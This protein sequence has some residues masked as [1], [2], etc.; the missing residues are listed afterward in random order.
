MSHPRFRRR[1][2]LAAFLL[3]A[4]L[5]T[6][7]VVGC[8]SEP[9]VDK[10]V[11]IPARYTALPAKKVPDVF[12]DTVYEKCDLINTEPFLVNGY[13]FVSNLDGTGSCEAPNAVRDYMVKEMM[14]HKWDSRLSGIRTPSPEEAMRDPRNAIVQVDGYLPPGVR[15]GQ[16][17]DIQVSALADSA[18]TSLAQGDLFQ[19]EL[20]IRGADPIDPGG[21]VNVFARAE[22][23]VFVNPEYALKADLESDAGARRSLRLGLIMNGARSLEDRPLG[24]RLRQPSNRTSRYI[25]QRIDQRLQEIRPDTI[26]AAQ[27]EGIVH[28]YVPAGLNG[29][30]EHFAGLVNFLYLN[31]SPEFA[32]QKARQL[33]DEAVKPGAPL[34]EISYAWEGLAKAALPVLRE[35]ELMTHANP[36]IA[37][38]AARAAACLNDAA[39]Q[40]AL[41]NIARTAGHKFQVNAVRVLGTMPSSPSINEALRPLLDSDENLVRLETYRTLARNKDSAVFS[42]PVRG[43]PEKGGF[44]LDVVR[45]SAPPV[46]YATQRGEPRIAVLGTRVGVNMPITFITLDNRLSISSN[47]DARSVTVFYRPRIPESGVSRRY[48]GMADPV[49][50]RSNPDIAE[51]I[52]RLGGEGGEGRKGSTLDFNYA[53]ILSILSVLTQNRQ[54]SAYA[55]GGQRAPASFILEELP[56]VQDEIYN[57]PPIPEQGRPQKDEDQ[58]S[59]K[60]VG[61]AK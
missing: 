50:V 20:R 45:S 24:L 38:A 58:T 54:L 3:A 30:W 36:D 33:A 42:T 60:Q 40:Q 29:D 18:T 23:P 34:Q 44:T 1:R 4:G 7:A 11:Q 59:G 55:N 57:A 27:D 17:F 21:S 46:I 15:K 48:L 61:M 28:V 32:A 49:S 56:R 10:K 8:S 26:A 52:A 37:Y 43:G 6:V 14:K 39:G 25:E 47:D 41:V 5:A 19:T 31:N 9:K 13:G 12:K 51:I 35:R 22:G 53:E 16:R 2:R